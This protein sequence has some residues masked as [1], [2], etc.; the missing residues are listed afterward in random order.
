M[1]F[2]QIGSDLIPDGDAAVELSASERVHA[3]LRTRIL[4]GDLRN[5]QRLVIRDLAKEYDVSDLPV[6]EAI[7]MLQS[8]GLAVVNKNRGACVITLT[9]EDIPGAYIL[10]GELEALATRL[11]GPHL[12]GT[13]IAELDAMAHEMELLA[14]RDETAEYIAANE[15]FHALIISRC[16]YANIRREVEKLMDGR[17]D[18]GVIFGIDTSQLRR[19]SSHHNR[20]VEC[21]KVGDWEQAAAV[22]LARK[23]E[24]ARFLLLT[25]NHP[26]PPELYHEASGDTDE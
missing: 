6:R 2:D 25:L 7:R 15:R 20:L 21:L 10:R 1:K 9:P 12:S 17:F 3:S 14:I 11:A 18:Y 16:P 8:D 23:L 24:V 19:S 5:G 26:V 13:D 22:S 4:Q